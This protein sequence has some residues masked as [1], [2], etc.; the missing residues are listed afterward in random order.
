MDG[1]GLLVT[2]HDNKALTNG[3]RIEFIKNHYNIGE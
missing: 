1:V 3:R 2:V